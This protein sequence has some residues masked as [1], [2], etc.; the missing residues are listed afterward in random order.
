M[1]LKIGVIGTGAIGK[2]HIHRITHKLKG[3]QVVAV[4]DVNLEQAR[5]VVEGENLQAKVYE[6]GVDVINASDVDALIVTSWGPTH[7]EFVLA[8]IAAGKPVF[9]EKP[10]AVTA[11]GCRQIVDA[12]MAAGRKLV[13]VGF[14]RRFDQSYR[15]LKQVLTANTIGAPLILNCSH[16]NPQSPSSDFSGDMALTDSCVHEFDVL[17]WLLDD[18]YVS[19]QVI[20]PRKTRLCD[21]ELQDPHVILLRTRQGIHISIESFVNCQYGYDIQCQVVGE[22]GTANLPEPASVPVRREAKLSSDILVSWKDRFIDAFDVEFQEWIDAT[23]R[24]EMTGPSAWD[25]Y[26]VALTGDAC[27]K[28]KYSGQIEP[29]ELPECPAFY[30]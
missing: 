16:R 25:G 7:E 1:T 28:A 8:S 18:D 6:R 2:E 5:A 12:E 3:A 27:V 11:E 29:I 19:A 17:R 22:T 30:R 26:V 24:G 23:V 20:Q 4:S 15:Q 9:C 14:M 21:A 10:L 13:Q